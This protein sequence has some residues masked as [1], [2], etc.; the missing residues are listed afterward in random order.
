MSA[1]RFSCV[2]K[3]LNPFKK[4]MSC[5]RAIC[6]STNCFIEAKKRN[7]LLKRKNNDFLNFLIVIWVN[8]KIEFEKIIQAFE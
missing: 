4:R 1:A 6:M 7:I 3:A 2:N 8:S 5:M